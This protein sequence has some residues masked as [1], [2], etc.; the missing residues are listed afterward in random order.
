MESN[1]LEVSDVEDLLVRDNDTTS[2]VTL[3]GKIIT[4]RSL[5]VAVQGGSDADVAQEIADSKGAGQ[6]T[7][8]AVSRIGQRPRRS[9]RRRGHLHDQLRQ[10]GRDTDTV[11]VPVTAQSGF[12]AEG[13][14]PYD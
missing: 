12:P 8:G 4:P 14:T 2:D 13:E 10:G 9:R 6:P 1:V 3:Q 7:V 5:Y 11:T